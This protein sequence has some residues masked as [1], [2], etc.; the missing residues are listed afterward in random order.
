MSEAM[1][2]VLLKCVQFAISKNAWISTIDGVA[3]QE[4]CMEDALAFLQE[5]EADA[6]WS[7][8]SA[9]TEAK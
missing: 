3:D 2:E 4:I 1:R 8:F 7:V 5:L 6:N 9:I